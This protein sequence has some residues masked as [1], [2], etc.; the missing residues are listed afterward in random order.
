MLV[1]VLCSP[2]TSIPESCRWLKES[3]VSLFD[4]GNSAIGMS[5]L[6]TDLLLLFMIGSVRKE[7]IS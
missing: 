7:R 4:S 3:S 5:N 6:S 1:H 2:I